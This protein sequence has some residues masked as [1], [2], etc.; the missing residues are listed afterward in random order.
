M[1][2]FALILAAATLLCPAQKKKDAELPNQV[3][4]P[5]RDP[6][7]TVTVDPARLVFRMSPLSSKGLL[8][9]Q[10]RDALKW[11]IKQNRGIVKLRAFV[12]GSGDVRRVQAIAAELFSEKRLPLPAISVVQVGSLPF[13][14]VQVAI[15]SIASDPKRRPNPDGLAFVSGQLASVNR[16]YQPIRPLAEQSVT[17]LAET[18]MKA[19]VAVPDVLRIT[20]FC[21]STDG[22]QYLRERLYRDYRKA[23]INLVQQTREPYR[24]LVECEAVG[25]LGK[26]PQRPIVFLN[27]VESRYSHI[28]LVNAPKLVI[29]GTQLAFGVRDD[30]ARLAFQRLGKALEQ[31]GTSF[32]NVIVSNIYPLSWPVADLVRKIRPEFYPAQGAPPPA[33]TMVAFEGLPS[34]DASFAVDVVATLP[35]K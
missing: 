31:A 21:S 11:L 4:E 27:P 35:E 6:P 33:G 20:C 9:S 25:R 12:A 24:T 7:M 19:G 29:S 26:P 34:L 13:P 17:Q 14:G 8:S 15:E 32:Q 3:L 22:M 30:D 5:V 1:R 16:P 23:A 18:L 28:A 10:T 2:R